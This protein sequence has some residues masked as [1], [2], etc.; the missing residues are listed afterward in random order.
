MI[1]G[2][3]MREHYLATSLYESVS[4][5]LVSRVCF[6]DNLFYDPS[7]GFFRQ[8]RRTGPETSPYR[9]NYAPLEYLEDGHVYLWRVNPFGNRELVRVDRVAWFFVHGS[10]ADDIEHIDGDKTNNR[11]DNLREIKH[12]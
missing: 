5:D 3:K 2:H 7:T 8:F 12:D 11:I 10:W 9:L 4:D 6:D 1:T